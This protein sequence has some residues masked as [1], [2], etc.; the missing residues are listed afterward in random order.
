MDMSKT[1]SPYFFNS[2]FKLDDRDLSDK[3][4]GLHNVNIRLIDT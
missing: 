1:Y 3:W 2:A 4:Q